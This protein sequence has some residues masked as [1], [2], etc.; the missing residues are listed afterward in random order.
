MTKKNKGGR[1]K[2]YTDDIVIKHGQGLLEFMKTD[3]NVWLKDYCIKNDFPS[4]Y[5][6][7]W[8]KE[9]EEFSQSYKKA[10][11]IQESKF[12]DMGLKAKTNVAFIIFTLRNVAKWKNEDQEDDE[13]V[14]P[15]EINIILPSSM[16]MN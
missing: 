4:E 1:P 11:D 12:V 9:N 6:S 13:K 5:L 15:D 3:G 8:S 14:L 10:K 16:N 2:K 7:V